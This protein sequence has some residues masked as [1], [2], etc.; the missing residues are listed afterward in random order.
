[1]PSPPPPPPSPT[2]KESKRKASP[3][4]AGSKRK[5]RIVKVHLND[6]GRFFLYFEIWDNNF[7]PF[8]FAQALPRSEPE[9]SEYHTPINSEDSDA[10]H[11][12]VESDVPLKP[13]PVESFSSQDARSSAPVQVGFPP[14]NF[15]KLRF[16]TILQKI[17]CLKMN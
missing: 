15:I 1:M 9:L 6:L 17:I 8:L 3:P 2:P 12:A 16:D 7:S 13:A 10:F 5:E 14:C 4:S 11:S